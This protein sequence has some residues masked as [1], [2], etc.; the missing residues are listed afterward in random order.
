MAKCSKCNASLSGYG[1]GVV[2]GRTDSCP[3]CG[4]DIHSCIQCKHYDKSAYNECRE[5]QAER[6]V[7]KE[8]SNFCDYFSLSDKGG[9][10]SVNDEKAATMKKLDD[11]FK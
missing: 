3:A 6:V 7:D 5:P 10:S 2:V 4:S 8:R 11:L 9:N 1:A